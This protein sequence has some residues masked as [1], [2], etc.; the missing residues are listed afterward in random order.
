MAF[1]DPIKEQKT[2]MFKGL[3]CKMWGALLGIYIAFKYKEE[4]LNIYM[5]PFPTNLFGSCNPT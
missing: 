5:N 2:V 4:N 3:V 1:K